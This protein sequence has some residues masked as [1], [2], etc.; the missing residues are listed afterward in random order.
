MNRNIFGIL[1]VFIVA[2]AATA[3][4]LLPFKPFTIGNNH[5]ISS[6][7]LAI[8]LGIVI[9]NSFRLS[10]KLYPGIEF[11]VK[12]LLAV[13]IVL[14]GAKLNLGYI[15][16]SSSSVLI[17]DIFSV[18]LNLVVGF[19]MCKIARIEK[20][21][22]TLVVVGNSIC[23]SSAIIAIAPLIKAKQ[24]Q[25]S[26][27][28]IIT[29]LL[30]LMCIFIYPLLGKIFNMS[31]EIFG[32]WTGAS[33]QS[34]PQVVATGFSFDD[35]AG[36][37]SIIVKLI[38]VLLLA[39]TIAVILL[40][41]KKENVVDSISDKKWSSYVPPFILGFI[42]MIALNSIGVFD[43][44]IYEEKKLS[45]L[46]AIL[47]NFF[48]T[49]SMVSIGARTDLRTCFNVATKPLLLGLTSFVLTSLVTA[50]VI[51]LIIKIL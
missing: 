38:K 42:M 30:G 28:L 23:G 7:I 14:L 37:I 25:I 2:A 49:M 21:L 26:L 39:P 6:E 46:L 5:P 24:N 35:K 4:S 43:V 17:I 40:M 11:S 27:S 44:R 16:K 31:S 18:S 12:D 20:Q 10:E 48:I 8:I 41:Q 51:N 45:D 29:S 9:S 47:A 19:W 22:A 34:V 3:I 1:F 50:I 15:T 33:V 13:A 32:I 36:E